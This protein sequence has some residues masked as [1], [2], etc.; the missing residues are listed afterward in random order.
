MDKQVHNSDG[1]NFRVAV[2][3]ESN[4]ASE[5]AVKAARI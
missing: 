2:R 5:A 4:A 3:V 1:K